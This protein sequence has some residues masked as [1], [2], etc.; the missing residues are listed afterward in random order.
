MVIGTVT[1]RI[2]EMSSFSLGKNAGKRTIVFQLHLRLNYTLSSL[3]EFFSSSRLFW[4][5]TIHNCRK[6]QMFQSQ[7]EREEKN[8]FHTSNI[9]KAQ[10]KV[11][12]K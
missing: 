1:M 12:I 2:E 8:H 5:A 4:I 11:V 7:G 3:N 6:L 10:S 9:C